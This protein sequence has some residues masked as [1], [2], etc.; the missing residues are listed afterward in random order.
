MTE[1]LNA[2]DELETKIRTAISDEQIQFM[3]RHP[4]PEHGWETTRAAAPEIVAFKNDEID[5][6]IPRLSVKFFE[7][8][9]TDEDGYTWDT[10]SYVLDIRDMADPETRSYIIEDV[11]D[12][13]HD[14]AVIQDRDV[15]L[16]T[17]AHIMATA[18]NTRSTE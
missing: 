7:E 1:T 15:L 9:E 18:V 2:N 12:G 5:P 6:A 11:F 14:K 4:A 13:F 8:G 3:S 17:L 10:D 16:D